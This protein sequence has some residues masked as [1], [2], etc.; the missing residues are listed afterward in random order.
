[1]VVETGGTV[2]NSLGTIAA[3][4]GTVGTV[5]VQG[6]GSTWTNTDQV[7]VGHNGTGTLEVRN[8]G[9]LRSVRGFAGASAFSSG[10]ITVSDPGSTWTASG[11]F[12][13]G[14]SGSGLLQVLNGGVASTTGNSHLGIT[15]GAT[16]DV[17]VSGAGSTLNI[18]VLLNIGGDSAARTRHRLG[19]DRRR[20]HGERWVRDKSLQHRHARSRERD[21]LH[22]GH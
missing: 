5:L 21:H 16:G 4:S 6:A 3:S 13:I 10:T 8:G 11:S 20:R 14:N 2:S 7:S 9:T 12:F 18:G 22:R 15:A 19:T 1:M 17:N